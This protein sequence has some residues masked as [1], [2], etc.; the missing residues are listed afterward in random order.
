MKAITRRIRW[1][2]LAVAATAVM[3]LGLAGTAQ[4]A[5]TPV[6][7]TPAGATTV[8]EAI[9]T[10]SFNLLA[11]LWQTAPPLNNPNGI[12]DAP[13]NDFPTNGSTFGILTSGEVTLADDPDTSGA[14]GTADGGTPP[15]GRGTSAFDVSVLQMEFEVP[16]N[17]NCLTFDFKFFS[18]EY[19]EFVGSAFN[20]AFI[21]ELDTSTWT[22][23]LS[24]ITAPNNFAFDEDGEEVSVNTS[25]FSAGN[26]AGTTYDGATVLLSASTQVTPGLHTLYLSIFDQGDM[27]LDSSV[28][29]DN[30]RV[31]FVPNPGVNCAPGAQPV[32]FQMT[33]EPAS[34]ENPVGT[35]HTVTATLTDENGDPVVGATVQFEV[36]GANTAA[37][38]GVTDANGQTDFTYTGTT[39]GEDIITACYD[40]NLP[41]DGSCEA[42]ASATKTWVLPPEPT[43]PPEEDEDGDGLTD[44][45]E[46]LLLTLLGNPDSDGDGIVDGNDDA[47]GNGQDDEDED[48]DDECPDP[49]SDD[50]GTDDEDEDDDEDDQ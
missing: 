40:A 22:T 38:V 27:I 41:P 8:A 34:A 12:A 36:T 6:D 44:E 28:F 46:N 45:N 17:A 33:L 3:A 7:E 50:D 35:P 32:S 1:A 23:T 10:P 43:C 31:G 4:A 20:D 47:N 14:S 48:D 21:A 42:V 29:V 2:M 16:Q 26:A 30:L 9:R 5:I 15:P 39:P 24:D 13:L 11:A 18:E 25:G 49:D 37:G 19:P